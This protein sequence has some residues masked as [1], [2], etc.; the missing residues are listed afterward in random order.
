[1]KPDIIQ[2]EGKAK[3]KMLTGKNT[4]F[5]AHWRDTASQERGEIQE[6]CQ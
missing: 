1:M 3:V 6:R 4:Y 5:K 2:E